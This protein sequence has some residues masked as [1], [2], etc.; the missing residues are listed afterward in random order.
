MRTYKIIPIADIVR[1]GNNCDALERYDVRIIAE[2]IVM[3]LPI[4][5]FEV[6]ANGIVNQLTGIRDKDDLNDILVALLH[7]SIKLEHKLSS[8]GVNTKHII[9]SGW[10]GDSIAVLEEKDMSSSTVP[11]RNK[12]LIG[13]GIYSYK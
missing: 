7:L 10:R 4:Q 3:M 8:L 9:Y 11:V 1:W 6:I 13:N 5:D 2:K 12:K